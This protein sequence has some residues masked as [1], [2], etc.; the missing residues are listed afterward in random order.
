[1]P[2]FRPVGAYRSQAV[3]RFSTS[4]KRAISFRPMAGYE[5]LDLPCGKC[6]GCRMGRAR[7]WAMRCLHES[8]LYSLNCFL[9]LT[10]DD[11]H[12]PVDGSLSVRHLQ[13][14]MKR[15]R[16]WLSS[17]A[18]LRGTV[19]ASFYR[20]VDRV[21]FYACGEYGAKLMRPHYHVLLFGFDFHDKTFLKK[22]G[23]NS[24]YTSEVLSSLWSDP[25][26]NQPLGLSWIGDVSFRSAAYVARYVLKKQLGPDAHTKYWKRVDPA[27]GEICAV[28]PEFTV[29]SRRPG[30]GAEWFARYRDETYTDRGASV[31]VD[32]RELGTPRYYDT[33]L[34]KS[35]PDLLQWVKDVRLRKMAKYAQDNTPERLLVRETV[36]EARSK[37][38]RRAFEE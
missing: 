33:L 35:D 25:V 18:D 26:D 22:S 31:V 15:L 2:C 24:L 38:L 8:S 4:G 12:M 7:M 23:E 28:K 6:V 21:R 5:R 13:L 36:A 29:M 1:M 32:G 19:P 3:S 27:T 34:E 9:T 10:F 17:C 37:L 11:A 14:F 16:F 20:G 30:I